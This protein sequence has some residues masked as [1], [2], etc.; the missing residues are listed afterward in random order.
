MQVLYVPDSAGNTA[1]VMHA[2]LHVQQI[3]LIHLLLDHQLRIPC[4]LHIYKT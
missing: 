4:T 2:L 1:V 3:I